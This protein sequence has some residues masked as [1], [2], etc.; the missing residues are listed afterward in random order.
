MQRNRKDDDDD[1]DDDVCL[2]HSSN[3]IS[4]ILSLL[5]STKKY[6]LT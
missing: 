5:N 3:N 2:L 6:K 4:Y 1:Y